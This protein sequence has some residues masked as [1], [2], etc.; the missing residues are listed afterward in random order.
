MNPGEPKPR[1]R[2]AHMHAYMCTQHV[3]AHTSIHTHL[4]PRM[5]AHGHSPHKHRYCVHTL[6][7][8]HTQSTCPHRRDAGNVV[9]PPA[10]GSPHP[11]WAG[12]PAVG[13]THS[14]PG[15]ASPASCPAPQNAAARLETKEKQ[16]NDFLCST[17]V[18]LP[19]VLTPCLPST[20]NSD[21]AGGNGVSSNRTLRASLPRP[22]GR[23]HPME[24]R[25]RP[26]QSLPLGQG[27]FPWQAGACLWACLGHIRPPASSSA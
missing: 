12:R 13:S 25:A 24:P 18:F 5:C 10:L 14:S 16:V 26:D 9:A 8:A 22:L 17:Q 23:A 7:C 27:P 15:P 21:S 2:H 19:M 11:Q 20:A 3:P 6:T 1:H 4:H